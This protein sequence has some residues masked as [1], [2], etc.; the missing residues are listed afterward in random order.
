MTH[1]EHVAACWELGI[2]FIPTPRLAR[3]TISTCAVFENQTSVVKKKVKKAS[4]GFVCQEAM[5][6][7]L[8]ADSSSLSSSQREVKKSKSLN[9]CKQVSVAQTRMIERN[10]FTDFLEATSLPVNVPIHRHL[11]AIR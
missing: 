3:W 2:I 1:K 9:I 7:S 10:L 6:N 5:L 8:T 4:K 11:E